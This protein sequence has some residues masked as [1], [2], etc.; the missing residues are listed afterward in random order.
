VLAKQLLNDSKRKRMLLNVEYRYVTKA[1]GVGVYLISIPEL[2]DSIPERVAVMIIK[3]F[4]SYSVAYFAS[5]WL[6]QNAFVK[7]GY[8]AYGGEY[9]LVV[10]IFLLSYGVLH[11][12][13][14]YFRRTKV[15][16]KRE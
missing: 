10:L 4:F 8:K 12:F 7:R 15:W 1:S 16:T 6:V 2:K 3:L 5:L 14:R 11:T 13:F 9:I